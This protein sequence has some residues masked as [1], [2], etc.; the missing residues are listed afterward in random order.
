MKTSTTPAASPQ[1]LIGAVA[2]GMAAAAAQAAPVFSATYDVSVLQVRLD[3]SSDLGADVVDESTNFRAT[4]API[5]QSAIATR[6]GR[7][8]S[9]SITQTAPY[10]LADSYWA[11]SWSGSMDV[12]GWGYYG[13]FA[14]ARTAGFWYF[15][16]PGQT[17]EQNMNTTFYYASLWN[18]DS[19]ADIHPEFILGNGGL[20]PLSGSET[21]SFTLA[22][23]RRIGIPGYL[24]RPDFRG[25]THALDRNRNLPGHLDF[26]YQIAFSTTPIDASVF[27]PPAVSVPEPSTLALMLIGLAGALVR[28]NV[29]SG[30]LRPVPG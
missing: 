29:G 19:P 20:G 3:W 12:P 15:A 16:L 13:L 30:L 4:G 6:D 17:H 2:I 14:A 27:L 22:D 24:T 1:R 5:T 10:V 21:G 23:Y 7:T 26:S 28:K 11:A 25:S 18:V 9:A 8:I